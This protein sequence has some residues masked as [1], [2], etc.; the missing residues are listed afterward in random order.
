MRK[1]LDNKLHIYQTNDARF[2]CAIFYAK[3]KYK[4][5]SLKETEF[6]VAKETAH[7]WYFKLK[8]QKK[9]KGIPIHG[10]KFK[11]LLND[12]FEYQLVKVNSGEL[13]E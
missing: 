11:N 8:K 3:G 10:T 4:V 7:D 5:R 2:W 12:F 13:K 1:Y 9:E 6:Q